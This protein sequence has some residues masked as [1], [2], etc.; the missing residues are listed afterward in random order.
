MI[1]TEVQCT[2]L[3][4]ESKA[5]QHSTHMSLPGNHLVSYAPR[6]AW[7]SK[8]PRPPLLQ[9]PECVQ[10]SVIYGCGRGSCREN[11]LKLIIRS[12]YTP[13]CHGLMPSYPHVMAFTGGTEAFQSSA[14]EQ[15]Y[16]W[17]PIMYL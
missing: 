7:F 2:S 12:C 6:A 16:C 14:I 17:Q 13:S 11:T 9:A 10:R 15:P 3:S 8:I 5:V 1:I 4:N